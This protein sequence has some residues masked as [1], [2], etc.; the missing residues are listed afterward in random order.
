[1]KSRHTDAQMITA[2]KHVEA[3]RKVEAVPAVG[4]ANP[5]LA[6]SGVEALHCLKVLAIH[7]RFA[8][9]QLIRN[10]HGHFQEKGSPTTICRMAA[11]IFS[12]NASATDSWT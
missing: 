8:K 1:L 12:L 11:T 10:P 9:I 3:G 6:R 2:L 5:R 7:I 4:I